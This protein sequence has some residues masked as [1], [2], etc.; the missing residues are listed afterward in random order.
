MI[1][2]IPVDFDPFEEERVI[3]KITF[4]NEP[5]REIWLSCI[6][7]GAEA[8]LSYNESVSLK[9]EGDLHFGSLR[10]AVT[11]LVLRHEA[12][13]A[14][15]S[16]NGE[17]LIIYKDLPVDLDLMDISMMGIEDAMAVFQSFLKKEMNELL[18]IQEGPLFKMFLHKTGNEEYYLTIIKHH[19]IGDGWSTGIMLEDLSRM[20]NAYTKGE[21]ITLAP[22][23]QISDYASAQLAFKLTKAYKDTENYWLNLYKGDVPVVD[24]PTDRVR[25]AGK[26]YKGHRIDHPITKQMADQLKSV[27]AKQGASLVT[28]LLAAF[29]VLLYK[30]TRQDDLVV[31]LPASGQAATGLTNVVGHCVNLLP[32]R[33]YIDTALPFTGYLKRRKSEVLDAYDHQRLTFGELI[34]KLYIARDPSRI[35]LVPVMFNIDMGM[36][37]S[38]AFDG[39]K[40]KLISNPRDYET[41]EIYLNA[42]GSKDG[43]IMEWSYNTDLFD[44]DTI[45]AFNDSYEGIL[46]QIID[47]P[48]TTIGELAGEEEDNYERSTDEVA[49]ETSEAVVAVEATANDVYIAPDVT[50]IKLLEEAVIQYAD[51]PAVRFKTVP[52]TYKQL[53]EKADQLSTLLMQKGIGKGDIVAISLDRS[54]EMLVCLLGVLK[55]GATYLP[56]D[57]EYPLDRTRFMLIDSGARLLITAK[58]YKYKFLGTT[59]EL[60]IDEVWASLGIYIRQKPKHEINGSDIAYV[61]YTSGSTGQ[62]KGVKITHTNLAN[63]LL[64]MQSKPGITEHDRLL[65]IT[66]IS[67]DIAGL[68]L[69]LPLIS[70]ATLVLAETDATKDGRLLLYL[71]EKE[72][73]TMMQATPSSWQ[74]LLDAEWQQKFPL[75]MLS[76]GEALPGDLAEKLLA[77]GSELWNMYG[78]TE[79]TIWS[80]LRNIQ[81]GDKQ[82]TIGLPIN[83]TTVYVMDEQGKPVRAGKAGELYIGGMGVADGYLNRPELTEE[84]FVPDTFSNIPDAKLYRTGDLVKML[85]DGQLVCLGRIDHQ[86]KIR[87]HRIEL[88]EIETIATKQPGIKQAVVVAREDVPNDKRIVAYVTLNDKQDNAGNP[89]WKDRWDTLY[90]TGAENKQ[91]ESGDSSNIDGTLLESLEN[92][93]ELTQQLAEWL[94]TS[95]ARIKEL[96]AKR[97]YEIGSGAGQVMFELADGIDYYMATD[98]AQAAI[99]NISSRLAADDERWKHVKAGVAAA[100]DFSAIGSTQLDLVLIN[101]VAQYFPNTDY[102]INVVR[103]AI[104][105]LGQGG[106]LFIGDM[107]GKNSLEMYHAMDHFPRAADAT[108]LRQFNEVVENRMRIEEEFVADPAFFYLL[109]QL[110]PQITGVDVQLRKGQSVNETTKYHYD[111]WLHVGMPVDVVKPVVSKL[112]QD[113]TTVVQVEAMLQANGG[114]VTEIKHVVNSRTVRDHKLL[115]LLHSANPGTKVNDIR[116]EVENAVNGVHPD[117]FWALGDKHGFKAHVRWTTDGTDGMYDVVFVPVADK[118]MVPAYTIEGDEGDIHDFARTPIVNNEVRVPQE[119]IETWKHK[120]N[121]V[122][123]AYMV[124]DEFIV[125]QKFPLTPNAKIDRKALPKPQGRKA[126]EH[127]AKRTTLTANEQ[128]VSDIWQDILGLQDLD[129]ADDFFQLGGHSLLAVKVMVSI[130]KKTGKRLP[131]ATLFNNATIEK[132]AAQLSDEKPAE[133]WD[134]LVPIRTTGTKVPIFLVHGGGMNVL[135][136]KSVVE[137]FDADQ[138]VYGIQALGF[139]QKTD[140]PTTIQAIAKRYVQE[141]VKAYPSGP[142]ALAGYSLGGFLAFEIARQLKAMDKVVSFLGVM[143]TYAGNNMYVPSKTSRTVKKIARQFNK[144]PF[145]TKSFIDN[146]KEALE[147]Q[148]LTVQR[149]LQKVQTDGPLIPEDTFNEYEA[150]IYKKYSDALDNYV[151]TPLDIKIVL[152]R[153]KKRVYFLDDLVT[154]GWDKFALMGVNVYEVPGD[155]KTFLFPPNS[156]E[157]AKVMQQALAKE[158]KK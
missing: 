91:N 141:I 34:K 27:G 131:I 95:V 122:L 49:V 19:I 13:R 46:N 70:G 80:T 66:S 73:I 54:V 17:Q 150:A 109:P 97:I 154:L 140:V 155:H 128:I 145:Y 83:N 130:E 11:N 4:T 98:Y 143:D 5:Q 21:Q 117:V 44:A 119:L 50:L 75:K 94:H 2:F 57:P 112:W 16:P 65:A 100:D 148:L 157:F 101:S 118:L 110:I 138:P 62:P 149:R 99:N 82:I 35:P 45:N 68:E 127:G 12:L 14:T 51:K 156:N 39:L 111:V 1:S 126:Q 104:N 72:K 96:K 38:V 78:P 3:E 15:V 31:G 142:Y 81:A 92:S 153:V 29:E 133:V 47:T 135:L 147:Y 105:R 125:L 22:A 102:M 24:V 93:E 86:V 114:K 9:I 40:F 129:P 69:Y 76:G 103:Q 151:L 121:E 43:I 139:N 88:G 18:D 63:F 107:Q 152:F 33:T 124:P 108:T 87:G 90:E 42:T 26:T 64:S 58:E 8:N 74:M 30:I 132:L 59:K 53:N 144:I 137:Y 79:T 20:Y 85:P 55:A 84:K 120:L 36:D 37:N 89:S 28:T 113:L 7:G 123:P 115:Q 106:C 48:A 60:I 67:F 6:I 10:K 52:L 25:P 116:A 56:L 158:T 32:L 61:L 23:S 71:L 41:F 134:S 136:F 146:P 77:R